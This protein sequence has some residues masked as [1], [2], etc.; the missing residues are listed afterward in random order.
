MLTNFSSR[1]IFLKFAAAR[2]GKI[3]PGDRIVHCGFAEVRE[4]ERA[5]VAI[6]G[7]SGSLDKQGFAT[8]AR[9][10]TVIG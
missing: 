4:A 8:A 5:L 6:R 10:G 2:V 7:N 3:P 9:H 1:Q